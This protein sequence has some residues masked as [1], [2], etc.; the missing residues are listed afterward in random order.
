MVPV[1]RIHFKIKINRRLF[2]LGTLL[3]CVG[4]FLFVREHTL[5]SFRLGLWTW[6]ISSG[7]ILFFVSIDTDQTA[8][9]NESL[10]ETFIIRSQEQTKTISKDKI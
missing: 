2:W 6:L 5:D 10:S 4:I 9:L 3:I 8:V 1:K 7:L